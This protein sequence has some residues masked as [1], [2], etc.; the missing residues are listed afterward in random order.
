MLA[1]TKAIAPIEQASIT[2]RFNRSA[3]AP[4]IGPKSANGNIH[5][6]GTTDTSSGEFV[7]SNV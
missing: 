1:D 3:T 2:R 6:N 5:N 7:V 4:T